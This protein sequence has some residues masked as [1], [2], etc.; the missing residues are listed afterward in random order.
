MPIALTKK[1][2]SKAHGLGFHLVGVTT[3]DPSTS[4]GVY[5]EWLGAGHH[6]EMGYL[7]TERA[8]QCRANP[9]QILPE[10]KSVLVLGIHYPPQRTMDSEK[11]QGKVAS[12]AWNED[13][14]E[15]LK[16]RLQALVTFLEE[17]TGSPVPNRWY[18][19][20]GPIL[21]RDLAQQ[22]GLGW[23]GK[24]SML[25]NPKVGSYFL[26]AEI[27][28]GIP[29][30]LDLPLNLDHCGSCTRCIDACPTSCILPNRTL[31]ASKCISY[32]TI[33]LKGSIPAELRP[34]IGDWIFGCDV[35]QQ[36]CPWN[37][38]FA[39]EEGD[40]AFAPRPD[41]PVVDLIEE[42]SL[43]PETFNKKF[44]GSP[45]K[46]AKRQGYL[47]NVTVALGNTGDSAAIPALAKALLEDPELLIRQHAAWALGQIGGEESELTLNQAKAKE[48]DQGVLEEIKAALNENQD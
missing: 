2:K 16:F 9:L 39:P 31:D 43:T 13:Y 35:C 17:E 6:G 10:C 5:E 24:N 34:Q 1:L 45:V 22:A 25:I 18:T 4:F 33:E 26:L 40:P 15:V 30:E 28:L 36:V 32:L 48:K 37:L 38:R 11:S 21:E 44:Q 27:L 47:R 3:P 20:T 29:L 19:D 23:I 42:L 14:H 8:R 7:E 46:R 12:Y 41:I